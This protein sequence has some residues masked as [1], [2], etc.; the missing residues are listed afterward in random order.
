MHKTGAECGQK[1]L[2]TVVG[3]LL[4]VDVVR[5][6]YGRFDWVVIS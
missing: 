2:L 3:D 1:A 6:D 5:A 4:Q